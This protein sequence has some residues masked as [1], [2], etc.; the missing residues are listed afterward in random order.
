MLFKRDSGKKCGR[1]GEFKSFAEFNFRDKE[2]KKMRGICKPCE[3]THKA[4]WY[5]KNKETHIE[6]V[7]EQRKLIEKLFRHGA[8]SF[9]IELFQK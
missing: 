8:N 1:C 2:H 3:N 9:N 6:N 7:G 5:R 4:N